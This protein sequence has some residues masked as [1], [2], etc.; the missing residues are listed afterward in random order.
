MK[1]PTQANELRDGVDRI[2]PLGKCTRRWS[3]RLHARPHLL[4]YKAIGVGVSRDLLWVILHHRL[5]A[6][7]DRRLT[8]ITRTLNPFRGRLDSDIAT[9]I[10]CVALLKPGCSIPHVMPQIEV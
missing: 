10:L 1:E 7:G 6:V 3:I 2:D 9:R 5:I 8:S 4:G